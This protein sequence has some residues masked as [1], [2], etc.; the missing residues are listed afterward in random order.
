[1]ALSKKFALK[2]SYKTLIKN[3]HV[4]ISFKAKL[5]EQLQMMLQ[6]INKCQ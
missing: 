2:H 4:L 5:H 1:M 6:T 3:L